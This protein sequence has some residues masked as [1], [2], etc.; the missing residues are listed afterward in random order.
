VANASPPRSSILFLPGGKIIFHRQAF[1]LQLT[2]HLEL[3]NNVYKYIVQVLSA[4]PPIDLVHPERAAQKRIL[5]PRN[6][7][8][9]SSFH[10]SYLGLT[11]ACQLVREEFLPMWDANFVANIQLRDL[12]AHLTG[13]VA[14]GSLVEKRIYVKEQDTHVFDIWPLIVLDLQPNVKLDMSVDLVPFP[15]LFEEARTNSQWDSYLRQCISRVLVNVERDVAKSNVGEVEGV[16]MIVK[17]ECTE[18]WMWA[19]DLKLDKTYLKH[20]KL[21]R[22]LMGMEDQKYL[23]GFQEWKDMVGLGQHWGMIYVMAD[24]KLADGPLG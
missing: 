19:Q 20:P 6:T 9:W 24:E 12:H 10:R 7:K 18:E 2:M 13:I 15:R 8:D 23:K 17:P 21:W 4:Q 22:R 1:T 14:P 5:G 3:R 16:Y 11:Q